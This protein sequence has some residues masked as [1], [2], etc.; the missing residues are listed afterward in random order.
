[1]TAVTVDPATEGRRR[2]TITLRDAAGTEHSWR[3][4]LPEV[5]GLVVRHGDAI[6][7]TAGVEGGGP[8]ARGTILIVDDAGVPLLS[9][10]QL[11]PTWKADFGRRLSVDKGSTYTEA[12]HAVVVTDGTARADVEGT[13]REITLGGAKFYAQAGAAKR[14]LRPGKRAPPDYVGSWIDLTL[15]RVP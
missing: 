7:V 11:P 4:E 13:W 10:K 8:N 3:V 9:I 14:K 5:L 12:Q 6:A 2:W 15:V 1:V